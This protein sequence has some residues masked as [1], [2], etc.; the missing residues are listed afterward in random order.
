M[1]AND[2]L[3]VGFLEIKAR[4]PALLEQKGNAESSMFGG[5]LNVVSNL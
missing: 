3:F 5:R 4:F 1:K 2:P